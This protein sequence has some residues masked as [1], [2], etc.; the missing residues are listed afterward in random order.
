M[1]TLKTTLSLLLCLTTAAA[2]S[3]K[4][5]KVQPKLFDGYPAVMPLSTSL[6][7]KTF[8][9]KQGQ[10]VT[11]DFSNNFHFTGTVLNNQRKYD[12]LQTVMIKSTSFGNSIFT[13]SEVI[14]PDKTISYKGRIINPDAFDGYEIKKDAKDNYSFAKFETNKILQPC[15]Y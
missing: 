3:Q 15:S 4:F 12:N 5:E 2:F 1:K 13:L 10:Q 7:Q 14:N 8:N 6:L 9:A 11:V